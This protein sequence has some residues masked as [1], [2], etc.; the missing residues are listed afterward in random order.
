MGFLMGV[1]P[2]II[3]ALSGSGGAL[4]KVLE[5]GKSMIT[6]KEQ[7]RDYERQMQALFAQTEARITEAAGRVVVAE[8]SGQ[9]WM[10]RNWRPIL[11]FFLMG[12]LAWNIVIAP[13]IGIEDALAVI[14]AAVPSEL[15]VMLMVGMGGYIGGR[16]YEKGK[17]LDALQRVSAPGHTER[18]PR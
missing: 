13:L 1:L 11:M 14:W 6:D 8:I 17:A 5:I 18:T 10:Q 3:A 7:Q 9:S 12:L 4:G 2:S 15:L 16:S